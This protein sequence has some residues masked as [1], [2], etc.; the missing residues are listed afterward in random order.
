[1]VHAPVAPVR[2]MD[3]PSIGAPSVVRS[4]PEKV[5]DRRTRTTLRFVGPEMAKPA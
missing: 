3:A 1:M 5:T 4:T 2:L